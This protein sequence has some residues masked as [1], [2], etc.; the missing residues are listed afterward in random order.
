MPDSARPCKHPR[1]VI[2]SLS[3]SLFLSFSLSPSQTWPYQGWSHVA[4]SPTPFILR[5]PLDPAEAGPRQKIN[6]TCKRNAFIYGHFQKGL[7]N[8]NGTQLPVDEN[9]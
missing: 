7:Y 8:T 3:L 2:L 9:V 4:L 6:K 5:V 1:L